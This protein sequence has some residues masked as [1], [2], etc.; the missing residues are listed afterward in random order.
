VF[1][2]AILLIGNLIVLSV[3]LFRKAPATQPAVATTS[4]TAAPVTS[5]PA[6]PSSASAAPLAQEA[7]PAPSVEYETI[8]RSESPLAD[9]DEPTLVR[10]IDE[11]PP[12][13]STAAEPATN[14]G[15][16]PE[17][18]IDMHAYARDP[19]D[20]FVYINKRKYTE[21]QLLKE[22]HRIAEI[23]ADGVVL[24]HQG[25]QFKLQRP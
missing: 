18:H 3:V 13:A 22:G 16:A 14:A 4:T 19:K 25:Q 17:L 6:A 21:G 23:T 20:R 1:A 12:P 8:P 2:L 11:T 7:A 24:L 9:S 10:R 5:S 15:G